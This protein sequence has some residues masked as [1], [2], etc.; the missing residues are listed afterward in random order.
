MSTKRAY[1]P[2]PLRL[3]K[4]IVYRASTAAVVASFFILLLVARLFQLQIVEHER[5]ATQ[6]TDNRLT[7]QTIPPP[8]GL[9]FDRNGN[10]LATNQI[11]PSLAVIKENV[12]DID[13]LLTNVRALVDFSAAEEISFRNRLENAQSD[14]RVIIKR[15]LNDEQLAIEAVNRHRFGNI[16]VITEIL[17]EYPYKALASHVVGSVRQITIEDL[18]QL[19]PVR[20]RGSKFVGRRGVENYYEDLLHGEIGLR[21]VEVNASGRIMS[22]ISVE[23]AT[24]GQTITLHLDIELQRVADKALGDRR[25]AVVAIDPKSG[26]VL[27]LVS[28]PSY[29]PNVF[30]TGLEGREYDNLSARADAPLFNRATQGK[31]P[32]GS[33]IKPVLGMAGLATGIIDWELEFD[34][35][36]GEFQLPGSDKVWRDWNWSKNGIGGQGQVDLFRSIYRSSNI[37]FFHLGAVLDI[38]TFAAFLGQWGYGRNTSLDIL[39][40]DPGILPNSDWKQNNTGDSWYPGDN[41]NLVIGQGFTLVTPLQ[42]ATIATIFANR[43]EFVRPRLLQSSEQ[44]VDLG[45]N[46]P[47]VLGVSESDWERMIEALT[48]VV[49]RGHKGYLQNGLAWF[50]IGMDIPYQ[51]AGKS[52]TAQVVAI[53]EGEEYDEELLPED[54]RKHALFFGFAPVHDPVIAVATVIENGGGGSEFAAPVVRQ[55]IDSYL[56]NVV[57]TNDE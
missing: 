20:Y 15:H 12:D 17:R 57:A 27:A 35:P 36:K 13:T 42:L 50:H 44:P 24:R 26:G 22:E 49:H 46:F 30:V 52:G 39:D 53:P 18:Q 56:A 8:R 6:A 21:Q 43:G 7:A 37:Y 16:L 31:Y 48:A 10:I 34:D 2:V 9:I 5:Y 55:V 41:M 32:P 33:T 51:M 14:D 25:G 38:E 28:K 23:P 54:Q 19:D 40:A 1:D 11:V 45:P 3:S 4:T 47:P 29:D